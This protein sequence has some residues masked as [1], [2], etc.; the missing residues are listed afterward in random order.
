MRKNG[1]AHRTG[2]CL[3][4]TLRI[5]TL[6]EAQLKHCLVAKGVPKIITVMM[7]WVAKFL[8]L[9]ALLYFAFWLALIFIGLLF[10]GTFLIPRLEA[11]DSVVGFDGEKLFPDHDAPEKSNDPKY[12]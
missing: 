10:F 2:Y 3:G 9:G 11:E 8:L 6:R 7:F 12:D 4:R 1:F 5:Y